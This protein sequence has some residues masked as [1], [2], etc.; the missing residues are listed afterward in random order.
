MRIRRAVIK[1]NGGRKPVA[2]ITDRAK[3]Y[4]A[5]A[6]GFRPGPP[7][8]CGFCGLKKNVGV[9]HING[10][11]D[12]GAPE[13]LMWGCKSC[14]AIAAVLMKRAGVGKRTQQYN[15]AKMSKRAM[16]DAYGAAI[17]V[18]RGQ[19]EGDIGKAIATI[20]GTPRDVRSAYTS[21]TWP[22][23]RAI[24]GSSGRQQRLGFDDVPF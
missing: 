2:A 21:R 8:Q 14:N 11:E 12:D 1:M 9:C 22:T 24:Y 20:R 3:R 5:N 18:M 10:N 15:P 16:M 13:N 7:K 4:R 23:R 19:F 6:E 17:K